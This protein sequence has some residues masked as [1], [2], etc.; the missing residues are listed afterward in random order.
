MNSLFY[1]LNEDAVEE[2]GYNPRQVVKRSLS[3]HDARRDFTVN[4]LLYNLNEDAVEDT[5]CHPR[6]S[7]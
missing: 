3:F 2:T 4:S 7:Y 5:V 6:H 1:N